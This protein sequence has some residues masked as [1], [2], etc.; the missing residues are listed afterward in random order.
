MKDVLEKSLTQILANKTDL[1]DDILLELGSE[2]SQLIEIFG[3][4][5]TGKSYLFKRLSEVLKSKKIMHVNYIPSFFVFNHISDL[6]QSISKQI[7]TTLFTEIRASWNAKSTN[8]YNFFYYLSSILR[9]KE[10]L[11]PMVLLIDSADILDQ[12]TIDFIQYF[13]QFVS[14]Y[15]IHIVAFTS[16]ELFPFS[17]KKNLEYFKAHEISLIL[18]ELFLSEPKEN[19]ID[20]EI[21]ESITGGNLF[22]IENIIASSIVDGK[23]SRAE[24]HRQLNKTTNAENLYSERLEQLNEKELETMLYIL[25]CDG[26]A[27]PPVLEELLGIKSQALQKII[28]R[29]EKGHYIGV[30][31]DNFYI[32]KVGFFDKFIKDKANNSFASYTNNFFDYLKRK[33][34]NEASYIKHYFLKNKYMPAAVKKEIA[35]LKDINDHNALLEVFELSLKHIKQVKEQISMQKDLGISYRNIKQYEK[36]SD[37]FRYILKISIANDYPVEEIAYLLAKTLFDLSS[38]K[39]AL[40]IIKTYY[41][42]NFDP[43]WKAQ[44]EHLRAE[45]L[46]DQED[47]NEAIKSIDKTLEYAISIDDKD[48]S[49][50]IQA[51]AKKTVG[52]IYYYINMLEKAESAFKEAESIYKSIKCNYGLAAIYNNLGVIKM[53]QGDWEETERLYLESLKLEQEH[54]NLEGIAVCYNNLGS[55]ADDQGDYKKSL[56]YFN[57]ALSIQKLLAERYNISNCYNNIGVTY[58]D[59]REYDKAIE[60]YEKSLQTAV[61]FNLFKNIIASLNNLGAVYFIVGN[62]TKA[63]EYYESAIKKS[64]EM[65][66]MEGLLRSYNNLGELYEKRGEYNLAHDLYIK[67]QNI[68]NNI[69]D[70]YLKAELFGN[71]GSVLTQ[72]HKFGEA[73]GY[74]V[75]SF[76]FFKSLNA[77]DKILESSIKHAWYFILTHNNESADY[78]LKLAEKT[79]LELNNQLHLGNINIMRAM[80]EKRDIEVSKPYLEKA[81][82]IFKTN[83]NL[84]ELSLAYYEYAVLLNDMGDWEQALHILTNNI[85]IVKNYGAIKFLEQNELLSQKIAK[86]HSGELK[87]TKFQESLLNKFSEV[88]Q[89]LNSI[90][91]FI[92]LLETSLELLVE[93]SEA[94]GG[95]L[96]LY[97]STDSVDS[98]EYQLF[99]NFSTNEK[100]YDSMLDLIHKSYKNNQNY[101]YKQPA[102]A[103][104][105]NDIA[106]FS[107]NIRNNTIGVILLFSK[108]GS[109]YFAE[110]MINLLNSLCNQIIVIIENIRHS[111]L[112]KSHAVLREELESGNQFTNMIGKSSKMIEIFE[113]IDKIK[114]SP[115]TVL[116]EGPSGTGKE[117]IARAIHYNSNRRNKKFVAQYCGALTETLLESELFG[118]VKGSFT[119]A[120]HD[121]KGLFEVA[122]GGTFFLDEIAD[123]SLSTQAKLLRFLQEG[124]IKRVGSTVTEKVDV[125]V[126]CATNTSMME[127]VKQG[128][129]R[130][131]LYYRLNVIRI[132]MPSLQERKSDIPL[133]A[134][135]FLDKYKQRINKKIIGI[136]D[137]AMRCLVNYEW[138]GN[139]RQLENEIERAVTLA[140]ND[141]LIKAS[142]WSEEVYRYQENKDLGKDENVKK[143]LKEAI[144]DLEKQMILNTMA[145]VGGNQS[146][147][148]IM[149]GISRQGLIKKLKRYA[150][151]DEQDEVDE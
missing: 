130:L 101:T 1:I 18:N 110:K 54:Y 113:L 41:S 40:E 94:D 4:S 142:D 79:A 138:P 48:F 31:E 27:K 46:T 117:L 133:L 62:W 67:G 2:T 6:L 87:E 22:L 118:H 23:G 25:L 12:Y 144:E 100:D 66:F 80:L 103:M 84:F 63:I 51:E 150:P 122:D 26:S 58:M 38:Y 47:F 37:V 74:L 82:E 45:I 71:L 33:N 96:S 123:I 5:G 10:L 126:I 120:T 129:F 136:T 140:E 32:K 39:F 34:V 44:F 125:R 91:D 16:R 68:I 76:D 85:S 64:E 115:T 97:K 50:S 75:E 121:K 70:D 116:V 119:G 109:H 111:N 57:E 36:A 141:S 42:D 92:T 114:D 88:I 29:L 59:N 151:T 149:L 21:I 137:E 148:A 83:Q 81:I 3:H 102:F 8:K 105:Y 13:I 72:L 30:N 61:S 104:Q 99:N 73:Y 43:V 55:L 134:I 106:T 86:E 98:W 28:N 128:E 9:E 24:L 53:F 108:H 52:K 124:E 143:T 14:S 131:D 69:N 93:F 65:G 49:K 20:A 147:A 112:E 56:T 77:K 35:Y 132:Q 90:T 146:H 19:D 139:I 107:L 89:K 95:I 7:D 145:E 15:K 17:T 127:R 78:Y 135:H 11:K 60:A